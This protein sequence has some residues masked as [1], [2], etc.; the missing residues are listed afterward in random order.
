MKI[1]AFFI[2]I[3][4][5][6]V[7]WFVLSTILMAITDSTAISFLI[8]SALALW[9]FVVLIRKLVK[10]QPSA[11]LTNTVLV[12]I[13]E[14]DTVLKGSRQTSRNGVPREVYIS[15][16]ELY[17]IIELERKQNHEDGSDYIMA[18]FDGKDI[19]YVPKEIVSK[20]TGY[21]DD[22]KTV[23]CRVKKTYKKDDIINCVVEFEIFERVKK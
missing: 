16:L 14:I 10:S 12:K 21:M 5:L 22:G 1:F 17:D 4:L 8:A 9:G 11:E 2:Y 7:G 20:I 23:E 6:F 18:L 15:D 13:D 19:G 3:I